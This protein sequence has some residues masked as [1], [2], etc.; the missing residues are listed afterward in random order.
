MDDIT[1]LVNGRSDVDES[2]SDIQVLCKNVSSPSLN[3][4]S[5]D[6]SVDRYLGGKERYCNK[7]GSPMTRWINEACKEVRALIGIYFLDIV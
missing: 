4:N 1:V 6:N 3:L 7:E 5:V 2:Y